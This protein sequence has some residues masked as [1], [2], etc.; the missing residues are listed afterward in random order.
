[1]VN[2]GAPDRDTP[3]ATTPAAA[4]PPAGDGPWPYVGVGCL[5]A[6][7]GVV[8]GGM[9]GVLLAKLLGAVQGCTPD[10]ETGSPCNWDTYWTWGARIGIVALPSISIFLLRRARRRA[11]ITE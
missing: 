2:P 1:M 10:P 3:A 4:T 5:T 11:A 6:I 7:V 9:I 8:A